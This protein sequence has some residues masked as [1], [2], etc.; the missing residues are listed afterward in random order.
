MEDLGLSE[1]EVVDLLPVVRRVV[2]S[3][4]HDPHLVEDLTQEAIA[5][6]VAAR[7]RV[8][9]EL[10]PYAVTVARNLVA[11]TARQADRDRRHEPRLVE[12]EPPDLS[13]GGDLLRE[14]DRS[15]VGV[16]MSHLDRDEQQLLLRHEVEDASTAVI[17]EELGS[18]A[19]AVAAR[20]ARTRAKLR[21][22]YLLERE[23]V[24]LPTER[25]RPVL[26]AVSAND[27]RRQEALDTAGHLLGCDVC[28]HLAAA[29]REARPAAADDERDDEARIT[30]ERDADVVV[31][32]QRAREVAVLAG[33]G[34]TDLTLVATA[35]SEVAR[36]I[37]K[38]AHRG[39][40][41]VQHVTEGGHEGVR[42]VA[43]DAGPGIPDVQAALRDGFSTYAGLGLGLPGARRLMDEFDIVSEH[44]SGTTVTMLKW[45]GGPP[46]REGKR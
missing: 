22:E 5:R 17:A 39:E 24:E 46:T 27:R 41:L 33:F 11:E 29:L 18:T 34:Q 3:R 13:P 45:H 36:N 12:P 14:E 19:G 32:R 44:G 23:H 43:R 26:R 37:V 16:A 15:H 10:L 31:A 8:D 7:A 1:S 6:V 21:V 42:V 28:A 30:V 35:V 25:C 2:A 9:G 38:F 40:V 4:V 20:L